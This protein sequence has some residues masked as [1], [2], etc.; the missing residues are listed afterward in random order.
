MKRSLMEFWPAILHLWKYVFSELS[1][2]PI[3]KAA[4]Q[5]TSDLSKNKIKWKKITKE[6]IV[7][8]DVHFIIGANLKRTVD[9][10]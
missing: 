6:Q 2:Q 8:C 7:L 9:G 10:Y 1:K 4:C 3:I 5:I